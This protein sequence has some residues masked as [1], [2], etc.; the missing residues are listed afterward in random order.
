MVG[1]PAVQ[2]L[3]LRF[4]QRRAGL[5]GGHAIENHLDQSDPLR[6]SHPVDT[7]LF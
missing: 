2:F 1:Q 5:L 4:G 6:D 3:S 7:Q